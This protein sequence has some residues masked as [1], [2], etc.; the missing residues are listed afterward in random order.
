MKPAGGSW[1]GLAHAGWKSQRVSK[2]MDLNSSYTDMTLMRL[3]YLI[4]GFL[5][6]L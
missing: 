5:L 2:E 1:T 6:F 4:A 3:G